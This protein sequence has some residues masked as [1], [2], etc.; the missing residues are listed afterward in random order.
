MVYGDFKCL[1]RRT[2]A[3]EA[4]RDKPCHI[5]KNQNMMDI[6]VNSLQWYIKF[7][8]KKLRMER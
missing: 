6:N 5:A 4:L 1:T 2:A 8:I 3:H 7:L